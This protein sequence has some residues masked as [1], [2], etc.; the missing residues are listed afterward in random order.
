GARP[1]PARNAAAT[2][3]LRHRESVRVRRR[4]SR[5]PATARSRAPRRVHPR[6]A[7]PARLPALAQTPR[8]PRGA[9]PR[10]R[11]F[12]AAGRSR[13]GSPRAR[14]RS[15]AASRATHRE[16]PAPPPRPARGCSR[17][18][19]YRARPPPAR[20]PARPG[21]AA[22]AATASQPSADTVMVEG[23][24][25]IGVG[26]SIRR[27]AAQDRTHFGI[28]SP[29]LIEKTVQSEFRTANGDDAR[30]AKVARGLGYLRIDRGF[31][32]PVGERRVVIRLGGAAPRSRGAILRERVG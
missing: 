1:P 18:R 23:G 25:P 28:A 19:A 9:P 15:S 29:L 21:H 4:V 26:E 6:A 11:D 20:T 17:S 3:R 14:C 31:Q 7:S 24:V 10:G 12:R 22:G 32:L 30:E 5:R 13:R 27:E 8:P 16:A 2:R